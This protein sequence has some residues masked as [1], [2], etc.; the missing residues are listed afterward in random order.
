M[1]NHALVF[2]QLIIKGKKHGVHP[3]IV[4]IR[5]EN[6]NPLPGITVGDIGPKMAFYAK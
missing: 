2:A 6:W 3:F 5:D 1:A 4:R